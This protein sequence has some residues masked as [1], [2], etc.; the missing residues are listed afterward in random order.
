MDTDTDTFTFYQGAMQT[1]RHP[2]DY[3]VYG[4]SVYNEHAVHDETVRDSVMRSIRNI[5]EKPGVYYDIILANLFDSDLPDETKKAIQKLC[6]DQIVLSALPGVTQKDLIVQV[7]KHII[8]SPYAKGLRE[9]FIN[10]LADIHNSCGS[11]RFGRIVSILDG[12]DDRVRICISDNSRIQ[13]IVLHI[14]KQLE[15]R[16]VYNNQTHHN[17]VKELLTEFEYTE[18]QM[19][20]WLEAILGVDIE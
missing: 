13:A 20:P 15:K 8:K 9:I 17:L 18:K 10:E 19:Q 7:W 4:H 11:G 6:S 16:K 1:Q 14:R 12:F 5:I 3:R 2:R